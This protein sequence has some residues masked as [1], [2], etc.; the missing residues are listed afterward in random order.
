M[1]MK[2]KV[3]RPEKLNK[4][5]MKNIPVLR[6]C[7]GVIIKRCFYQYYTALPLD[8]VTESADASDKGRLAQ[9]LR[10]LLRQVLSMKFQNAEGEDWETERR[11]DE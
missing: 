9:S 7:D 8:N 2:N 11:S 5:E 4:Y 10:I 6:T 1:P 3:Q